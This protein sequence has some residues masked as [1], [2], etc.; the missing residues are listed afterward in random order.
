MQKVLSSYRGV[1]LSLAL[2]L[3]LAS[4]VLMSPRKVQ[5]AS[6]ERIITFSGQRIPSVFEGLGPSHF[7]EESVSTRGKSREM[8]WLLEGTTLDGQLEARLRMACTTCS[9]D[10]SCTGHYEVLEDSSGCIEQP[11][12]ACQLPLNNAHTDTH[13]GFYDDGSY[14]SYCGQYCCSDAYL[15]SNP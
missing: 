14:V 1:S 6:N 7:A 5:A 13:N 2:G 8:S 11:P 4:L 3:A 12:G 10:T 15:C 9:N